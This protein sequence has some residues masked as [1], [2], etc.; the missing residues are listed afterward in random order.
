MYYI[1][2]S[3]PYSSKRGVLQLHYN[4]TYINVYKGK[5]KHVDLKAK[6]KAKRQEEK[7]RD[8]KG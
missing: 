5:E 3:S 4:I 1:L 6:I 8:K 7:G 2:F